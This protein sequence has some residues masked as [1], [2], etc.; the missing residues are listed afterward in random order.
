MPLARA[1]FS[2]MLAIALG[3]AAGCETSPQQPLAAQSTVQ[4]EEPPAPVVSVTARMPSEIRSNFADMAIQRVEQD[5]AREEVAGAV[6]RMIASAPICM[7]WPALWLVEPERRNSFVVRYDLMLRDWSG[8]AVQ[9]AQARMD[10]FVAMGFLSKRDLPE[11][12]VGAVEYTI[13][14]EGRAHLRGVVGSGQRPNFCAP[15]ERRLVD[16][17]AM[18]WGQYPCGS[19]RVR[20]THVGDDWPSWARADA[21]RM[22]LAQTW[23]AIGET[24]QGEVSMSRQWYRQAPRGFE[25]GALRSACL[26]NERQR[27]VGDDLNLFA[28]SP[29]Q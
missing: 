26:D 14:S 1:I 12:G 11:L 19:L 22:R 15:A 24:G 16:I 5:V 28:S 2:M 7:Q 6:Q 23:P 20:F 4:E 27:I 8:G 10:E 3:A 25:N 29:V 21:T 9:S 18:E 17:T 13:T